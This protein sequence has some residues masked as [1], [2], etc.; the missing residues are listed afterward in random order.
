[1]T[2]SARWRTKNGGEEAPKANSR[3][4]AFNSSLGFKMV[5]ANSKIASHE[6]FRSIPQNSIHLW[7]P[8][9]DRSGANPG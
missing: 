9:H 1:M 7:I 6:L 4:N 5:K 3:L 2:F 8:N